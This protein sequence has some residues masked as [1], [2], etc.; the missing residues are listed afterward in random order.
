MSDEVKAE[1]LAQATQAVEELKRGFEM[2]YDPKPFASLM[3][4]ERQ[5]E[6]AVGVIWEAIWR[7]VGVDI[8]RSPFGQLA[9]RGMTKDELRR[10]FRICESWIRHARGDLGFSLEK[11]LDLLPHALRCELDGRQFD[12]ASLQ[13]RIWTPT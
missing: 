5:L 13:T 2:D 1:R 4:D 12:P 7:S 10:R 11:T 3:R 8:Q 9:Q 6:M